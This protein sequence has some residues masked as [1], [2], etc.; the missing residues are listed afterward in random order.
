M[1][2]LY[3]QFFEVL[4][5]H[6]YRVD[7]VLSK[8]MNRMRRKWSIASVEL[9]NSEDED[10]ESLTD[11]DVALIAYALYMNEVITAIIKKADPAF[12]INE[13]AEK[14][15]NAIRVTIGIS[16]KIYSFIDAAENASK[17]EDRDGNLSDLVYIK[18]SELQ[19]LIDDELP[20]KEPFPVFQ[21]YLTSL[22]SGIPEA[23]FDMDHDIVLTSNA[24]I[25]YLKLAL[26]LIAQ[27]RAV[28]LE[29]FIW[30]SVIEDLVLYTTSNMRQLY[31]D[32][33]K[34]ITGVESSTSR[35]TYCTSSIN[36]LMGMAVSFL[37]VE[38]DFVT[39]TKPKVEGMLNNIRDAFNNLVSQ[40]SWMDSMTKE[41]TL[42]KSQAMTH[43]I[44][45]P[46]YIFN[47]TL[48]ENKYKGVSG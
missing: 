6:L 38:K 14:I 4:I 3:R 35:S 42:Q 18:V 27:T 23:H 17:A 43:L 37:I 48:L 7:D 2:Y 25:L 15:T 40:A 24:D 8:R 28:D 19:K 41:S 9:E 26:N 5:S 11:S 1:S 10:V 13:S 20:T 30:W 33:S 47:R 36:R 39:E 21:K 12:K 29:A 34:T 45:F 46:N 32:Y 44:G 31:Y 16:K 22:L